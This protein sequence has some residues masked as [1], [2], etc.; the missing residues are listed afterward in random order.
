MSSS[1]GRVTPRRGAIERR[2]A[3]AGVP[4][5]AGPFSWSVAYG[6]LLFLS[7]I[8]GIDPATGS[9]IPGDAERIRLIFDHLAR[10]LE[11]HG[12]SPRDV[13]STR[14]FVTDMGRHRPLVN[15]AFVRFFGA[16]L[17]ARTIVEVRALNQDDT[18]E[19]EAI[20][21]CGGGARRS[22]ARRRRRR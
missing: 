18:I 3:I 6:R 17:P 11:A 14:V 8:R 10:I 12:A 22:G 1:A 16:D 15:D 9:P 4:E 7:G 20:A 13:V 21:A 5:P 2:G 19:L